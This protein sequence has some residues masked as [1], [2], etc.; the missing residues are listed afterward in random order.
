MLWFPCPLPAPTSAVHLWS[1]AE[2]SQ[3]AQWATEMDAFQEISKVW[4][5]GKSSHRDGWDKATATS[6]AELVLTRTEAESE[7]KSHC[8][9][10]QDFSGTPR[11]SEGNLWELQSWKTGVSPL[12]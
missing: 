1:K 11:E 8:S 6:K 10:E 3:E 9:Q 7:V 12:Q 2:S 4:A 5:A